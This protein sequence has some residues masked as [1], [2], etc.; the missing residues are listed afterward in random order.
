MS[1]GRPNS[2]ACS[3]TSKQKKAAENEKTEAAVPKGKGRELWFSP[4]IISLEA[5]E[6]TEQHKSLNEDGIPG[7]IPADELIVIEAYE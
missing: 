6:A 2:V 1:R 5:Q 7:G 3:A 4:T